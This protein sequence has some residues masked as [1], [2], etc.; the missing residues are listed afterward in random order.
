MS[1]S[2]PLLKKC[3]E[4][5]LEILC[6]GMP[7]LNWKLMLSSTERMTIINTWSGCCASEMERLAEIIT[8]EKGNEHFETMQN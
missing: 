3:L 7:W 1:A 8:V 2:V 5:D 6:M 4:E